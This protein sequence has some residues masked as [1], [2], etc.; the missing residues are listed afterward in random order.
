MLKTKYIVIGCLFLTASCNSFLDVDQ[1]DN[2]VQDEFWQNEDQL[3]SSLMGLYTSLHNCLNS[4]Q[5]WGDVRSVFYAP[6]A[7]DGYTDSY[8][9]FMEHDI[10]PTNGLLSWG[11]VYTSINWINSFIKNSPVVP[12]RDENVSEAEVNAM[13]GEAHALRALNYFYLVRAFREAPLISEPYESDDQDPNT[14]PSSEEELLD[15]I[16]GD[17]TFA[18]ENAPEDYATANERYG[19]IT[20]NAVRAI[21]ADVKLWRNQYQQ[22][23]ELCAELDAQYASSL[24]PPLDWYTIFSPG[25]SAESIFELQYLQEGPASP[26]FNWFSHVSTS[27]DNSRRYLGNTSAI[28]ITSQEELYPSQSE[29]YT[30]SDTIRLKPFAAFSPT[31]YDNGNGSGMEV[32]KFSGEA[33]WQDSYRAAENRNANFI[34][35]RYREI[36]FMKAE[37]YAMLGRYEEAEEMINIIRA[38]CDIPPLSAGGAG[39]GADFFTWLLLERSFELGFEGKEWF[40]AVRMSRREGYRDVLIELAANYN[41]LNRSYPVIRARL[42]D[43]ESW[44]LPYHLTEVENNTQLEQKEFY[45]NK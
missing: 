17:L 30:S 6:G 2:L 3:N 23:L 32:Y 42:L 19:R 25:N 35:Y 24:L 39:E 37:A 31:Q 8:G 34:F 43:Q 20:K 5:V 29:E 27:G 36:L 38:H 10:Y 44:F 7:G 4:Y 15:F 22:C 16:E 26:L 9:Q 1:P 28:T 41:A 11:S 40:A 13:L 14:A 12:E 45:M 18:L 21:W 33:A